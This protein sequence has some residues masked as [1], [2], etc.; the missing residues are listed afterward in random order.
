MSL[1]WRSLPDDYEPPRAP[2]IFG[3]EQRTRLL[4]LTAVLGDTYPAE[5]ARYSGA[6]ISSV[7]E[8]LDLLERGGLISTRQVVVRAVTLNPAYPAAKELRAFLLRI[9]EGYPAYQQIAEAIRRRPRRR[10]KHL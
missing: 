10:N 1:T 6:S 3:S 4:L 2:T 9:A 8:S 5:L 7:Q